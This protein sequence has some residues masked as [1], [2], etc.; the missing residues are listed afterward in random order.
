MIT[1]ANIRSILPGKIANIAMILSKRKGISGMEAMCRVAD[2][3]P[4]RPADDRRVAGWRV[5]HDYLCADQDGG[6]RPYLRIASRC[7]MLIDSM[8]SLMCDPL[9]PEDASDKPHRLTHAPEALRYA[10]MSRAAPPTP[11]KQFTFRRQRD[12]YDF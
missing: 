8:S 9:R 2:L 4:M 11:A 7:D 6:S 3:P 12:V 10:L 1:Q 5:V